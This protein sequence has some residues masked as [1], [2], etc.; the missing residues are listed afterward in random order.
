MKHLL[1]SQVD[2]TYVLFLHPS[3]FLPQTTAVTELEKLM[4][5]SLDDSQLSRG[6][7]GLLNDLETLLLQ[8]SQSDESAVFELKRISH[9]TL[10]ALIK[11]LQKIKAS[12]WHCVFLCLSSRC[13][14]LKAVQHK[15]LSF[16]RKSGNIPVDLVNSYWKQH[17]PN[18]Q[19]TYLELMPAMDENGISRNLQNEMVKTVFFITKVTASCFQTTGSSRSCHLCW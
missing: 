7:S 6:L 19:G 4:D 3:I 10:M 12:M 14:F 15:P 11:F 18:M 1:A 9:D 2:I 17:A 5:L 8:L 16:S 13:S